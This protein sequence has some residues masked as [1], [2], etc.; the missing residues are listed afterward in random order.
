MIA[1]YS[2]VQ[3]VAITLAPG[4]LVDGAQHDNPFGVEAL[5]S[6]PQRAFEVAEAVSWAAT[7]VV[8]L[9]LIG[10]YR[11]ATGSARQQLRW[12]C[13]TV[14][15]FLV[16]AVLVGV[17]GLFGVELVFPL[18]L[19][20]LVALPGAMAAAILRDHLY[21]IDVIVD[22]VVVYTL[23][24][25]VIA[26][27]C[28]VVTLLAHALF[29]GGEPPASAV[30]IVAIVAATLVVLPA[31]ER[32]GRLADRLVFGARA[33]PLHALGTFAE[34]SAAAGSIHDLAPR[35]AGLVADTTGAAVVVVY[36]RVDD[37]FAAVAA[38]AGPPVRRQRGVGGARRRAVALRPRRARRA[39]RRGAG[40][41][42]LTMP[43]P[44]R[45]RSSR[46]SRREGRSAWP[47]QCP[48]PV[49]RRVR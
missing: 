6:V 30:S 37:D 3:L 24:A 11:A 8:M 44:G 23:L 21:G 38:R 28:G 15:A 2:A 16:G 43:A 22:R 34:T 45:R 18:F 9:S 5:G 47:P 35:L 36:V 26:A 42:V 14:F 25:A 7:V 41:A 17:A 39:A 4:P 46:E 20:V 1:T 19:F 32:L 33:T 49:K 10:R 12:L 13:G 27:V 40:G 31:R 29:A 48:R